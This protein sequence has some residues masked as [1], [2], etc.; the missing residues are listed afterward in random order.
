IF[1]SSDKTGRYELYKMP[2][3]WG[4]RH[5]QI[6]RQGGL[7]PV[8]SADGKFL[9]YALNAD[10]PTSLCRV[11]I[12]GGVEEKL[13]YGLSYSLN[14]VVSDGRLYLLSIG[15]KPETSVLELYDIG[16]RT[17]KRLLTLNKGWYY[18]M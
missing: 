11:P 12:Q 1:Y 10:S 8:E 3:E 5:V 14:F 4:G 6:T 13:L 17:R 15:E 2:A 16:S 7:N 18:G 9:Y